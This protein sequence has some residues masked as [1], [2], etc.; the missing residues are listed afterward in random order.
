MTIAGT[1]L[2]EFE[3][4]M[5][6]TRRLLERV[7]HE[8]GQWKPHPKA[9]ALGHLAQLVAWLPGWVTNA[10]TTTELDLAGAGGYSFETTATLL[11]IFDKN[12]REAREALSKA[13]DTDFGVS[14]S[15]KRGGQVLMTVPRAAIVRQNI[16]HLVHHRGQLSV[17]LK[18]LDV[19]IPSIYGPSADERM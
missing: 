1:I 2:P 4:E 5:K 19:P 10:L 17:Y 7:P 18:L 12:V 14:W 16:S 3:Q 15:L 6:T 13:K 11:D 9:F 8:K